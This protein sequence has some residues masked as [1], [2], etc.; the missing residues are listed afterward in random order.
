MPSAD[1]IAMMKKACLR[2]QADADGWFAGEL[3]IDSLLGQWFDSDYQ[4]KEKYLT[5]SIVEGF[6]LSAEA[7]ES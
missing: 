4:S 5:V 7:F 1:V 6:T 2:G 3:T